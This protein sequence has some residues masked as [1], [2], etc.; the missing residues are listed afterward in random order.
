VHEFKVRLPAKVQKVNGVPPEPSTPAPVVHQE[1]RSSASESPVKTAPD[2][3]RSSGK[4][5]GDDERWMHQILSRIDSQS[6]HLLAHQ[7]ERIGEFQRAAVEIAMAVAGR[8]LLQQLES[9]ELPVDRIVQE[10]VGQFAS[11]SALTVYLNPLDLQLL[12][13]RLGDEPTLPHRTG[14]MTLLE[15]ATLGRGDCRVQDS[16]QILLSSLASQIETMR[17]ELMR[18]LRH[19]AA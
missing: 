10:I 2:T 4:Q 8:L 14:T 18:S 9:G 1:M 16:E 3:N 13:E 5:T 12:R 11:S 19:A 15:D 7:Q 17:D 6:S